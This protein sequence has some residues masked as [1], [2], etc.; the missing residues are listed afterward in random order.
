MIRHYN[1]VFG[2]FIIEVTAASLAEA[3]DKAMEEYYQLRK[4]AGD[5]D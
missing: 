3:R 2:K 5:S 1:F 4:S